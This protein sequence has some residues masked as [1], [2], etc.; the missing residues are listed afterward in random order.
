MV[1]QREGRRPRSIV[2][3]A[4]MTPIDLIHEFWRRMASND[5]ASVDPL[6]NP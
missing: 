4:D 2:H 3:H 1:P 5:F 6:P